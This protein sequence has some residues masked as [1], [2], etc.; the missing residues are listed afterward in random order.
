MP[1]DQE[2]AEDLERVFIHCCLRMPRIFY[3]TIKIQ[4]DPISLMKYYAYKLTEKVGF[5]GVKGEY[6]EENVKIHSQNLA[7]KDMESAGQ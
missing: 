2:V 5:N 6:R 7:I 3:V 1:S 4:K